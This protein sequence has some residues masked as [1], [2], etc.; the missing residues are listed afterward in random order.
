MLN[1]APL[2]VA[3]IIQNNK[4][5]FLLLSYNIFVVLTQKSGLSN[6][7]RPSILLSPILI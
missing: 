5:L 1:Y 2:R 7:K 6:T 4:Y 3:L